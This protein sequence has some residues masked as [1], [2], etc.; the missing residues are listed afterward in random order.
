MHMARVNRPAEDDVN[1]LVASEYRLQQLDRHCRHDNSSN[2]ALLWIA[3][4]TLPVVWFDPGNAWGFVDW[5]NWT[6]LKRSRRRFVP[7]R[8]SETNSWVKLKEEN[9]ICIGCNWWVLNFRQLFHHFFRTDSSLLSVSICSNSKA[10]F[11]ADHY[12]HLVNLLF[13][14]NDV[15]KKSYSRKSFLFC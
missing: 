12:Q 15:D 7:S 3:G 9:S 14:D 1:L 2:S 5:L 6:A 13:K 8:G 11:E 10:F 4:G